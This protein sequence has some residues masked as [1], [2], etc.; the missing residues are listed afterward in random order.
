MAHVLPDLSETDDRVFS[1]G[2]RHADTPT[3]LKHRDAQ[4]AE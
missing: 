2:V 4:R 1:V 3:N